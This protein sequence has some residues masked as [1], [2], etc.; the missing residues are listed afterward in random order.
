MLIVNICWLNVNVYVIPNLIDFHLSTNRFIHRIFFVLWPRAHI[1]NICSLLV[2]RYSYQSKK[3]IYS[4]EDILNQEIRSLSTGYRPILFSAIDYKSNIFFFLH[5]NQ[6][7]WVF[8]F[9]CKA[10]WNWSTNG[11]RFNCRLLNVAFDFF[12]Y[13]DFMNKANNDTPG[14]WFSIKLSN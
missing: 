5:M 6:N 2:F 10:M 9:S 12:Y 1:L 13:K 3:K 11:A 7:D 14:L 8:V 4:F